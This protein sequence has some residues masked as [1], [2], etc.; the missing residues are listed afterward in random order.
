[1][2]SRLDSKIGLPHYL[3]HRLFGTYQWVVVLPI[4]PGHGLQLGD[5]SLYRFFFCS[6]STR[7][8]K[9]IDIDASYM[10]L[11]KICGRGSVIRM[12][13][14]VDDTY[15][16]LAPFKEVIENLT[17]I[18]QGFGEVTGLCTNFQKSIIFPIRCGHIN[19][20]FLKGY[21]WACVLPVKVSWAPPFGLGFEMVR[22]F[23]H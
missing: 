12:S 20:M 19:M 9:F 2:D 13:L 4:K 6:Q 15:L 3:P 16:F 18:L 22:F 10:F 17:S 23:Q 5:P 11:H 7:L 14:Y 21:H 1:V 8:H